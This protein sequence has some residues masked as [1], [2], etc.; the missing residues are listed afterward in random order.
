MATQ[1]GMEDQFDLYDEQK[2]PYG[3]YLCTNELKI[4]E[5]FNIPCQI[6]IKIKN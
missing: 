1:W 2:N 4:G 6:F 5:V 3:V